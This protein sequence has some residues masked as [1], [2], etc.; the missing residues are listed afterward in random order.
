MKIIIPLMILIMTI[1]CSQYSS[2]D[3]C[4]INEM[5]KMPEGLNWGER[6]SFSDSVYRFC[7]QFPD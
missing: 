5:T 3:E 1:G 2:K 6:G 7:K 4:R